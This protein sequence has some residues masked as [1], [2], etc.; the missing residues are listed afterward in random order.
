MRARLARGQAVVRLTTLSGQPADLSRLSKLVVPS[1]IEI[2][3]VDLGWRCN[4][5]ATADDGQ[6][7]V[8]GD[9]ESG[10]RLISS[11]APELENLVAVA[12]EVL[13]CMRATRNVN[14]SDE[15]LS[16]S[17]LDDIA[18]LTPGSLLLSSDTW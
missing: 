1:G 6:I 18:A 12:S 17:T 14:H 4:V 16:S 13:R 10:R 9:L 3:I 2:E 5:V 7:A 11:A 15:A 8:I